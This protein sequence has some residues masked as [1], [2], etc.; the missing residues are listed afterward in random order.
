MQ[1]SIKT[2][3]I[4]FFAF[5]TNISYGQNNEVA[6]TIHGFKNTKGTALVLLYNN[7][8]GYPRKLEKAAQKKRVMIR[9]DKAIVSF[10][11]LPAGKYA[12]SV[13]HD[14]DGNG[15]LKTNF[16]GM[17]VEGVGSS[18]DPKGFPNFRKS[19]FEVKSQGKVN[20]SIKMVYL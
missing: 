14:V 20:L 13:I 10:K 6:A 1:M 2:V 9:N 4:V 7:S 18:N 5:I 3:L 8:D 16:I 17:P 19:A 11:N 15:K 12:I